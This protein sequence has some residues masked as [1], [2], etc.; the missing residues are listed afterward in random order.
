MAPLHGRRGLVPLRTPSPELRDLG[1]PP[2]TAPGPAWASQLPPCGPGLDAT[3]LAKSAPPSPDRGAPWGLTQRRR[4]PR[5]VAE[6][7]CP[8]LAAGLLASARPPFKGEAGPSR[9]YVKRLYFLSRTEPNRTSLVWRPSPP[10]RARLWAWPTRRHLWEKGPCV[11]HDTSH[12][13]D[14][15]G[16]RWVQTPAAQPCALGQNAFSLCLGFLTHELAL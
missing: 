13:T 12:G 6:G 15:K 4:C 8:C 16:G 3:G 11:C 7:C 1:S 14:C 10:L 2:G 9:F 5:T